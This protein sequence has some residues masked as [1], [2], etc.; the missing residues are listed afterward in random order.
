MAE[1]RPPV[2]PATNW[3]WVWFKTITPPGHTYNGKLIISCICMWFSVIII[4]EN[5]WHGY[6]KHGLRLLHWVYR[7]FLC[8]VNILSLLYIFIIVHIVTYFLVLCHCCRQRIVSSYMV[9]LFWW[10]PLSSSGVVCYRWCQGSCSLFYCNHSYCYLF[11]STLLL[12]IEWQEGHLACET[13]WFKCL[14]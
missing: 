1:E 14:K 2:D 11:F 12:L 4:T 8:N 5:C 13:S 7:V 10:M 9:C 6:T 3:L